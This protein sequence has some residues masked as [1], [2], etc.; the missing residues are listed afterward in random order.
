MTSSP[1]AFD[2]LI[3]GAGPAGSAAAFHCAKRGLEVLL[4]DAATFPRDKTCGDGLTPR[5]ISELRTLGLADTVTQHYR[6]HGLK[7]H[8][9]G[10]SIT[11]P[12]PDSEFGRIGSAMP[13]TEFD[14]LL[15][16]RAAARPEVSMWQDATALRP[17]FEDGKLHEVTVRHRGVETR[18]RCGFV[19][20]ADGVRSTFGKQLGRQWHRSEVYGI[21][22]RSYCATPA[23]HEPWIHSHLELRDDSGTAQPGYGWIF[24]LGNGQV[25]LGC[26][27]L[28]T[29][30]RP[31]KINT[32]KLL[33]L[34]A[35]QQQ[36]TWELSEP[37]SIASALL[38]MGG[39]VSNVAGANWV[40][41]GDAAACVNPLNGEGIDYG[42]ET[43][44]LAATL[45]NTTRDC[46]LIWPFLLREHYGDAFILARTLARALTFPRAVT[47]LGPLAFRGPQASLLMRSAARLMGNLVTD[48]DRDLVACI[49]RRAGAALPRKQ[50]WDTT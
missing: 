1:T 16:S 47:S 3:V 30:S 31:A 23:S 37:H 9:F 50:L 15:R 46:T 25:N 42:L 12:W 2:V 18:I 41:I 24:P 7:L 29:T 21:A 14:E 26:G 4:I 49:W 34:Y 48:T 13:R 36:D 17:H 27:A 10:G 38:P 6:S 5:A 44:R 20:V 28:S 8:G 40:L 43:A 19:I 39:A 11:A 45:P 33:R 22:A 32:K 35:H